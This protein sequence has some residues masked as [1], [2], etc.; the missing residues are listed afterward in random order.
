M[1][2]PPSRREQQQR[3]RIAQE[4][5]RLMI[6]GGLNDF[7]AAKR[8]AAERLGLGDQRQLLPNNREVEEARV[9]YQRL[10]RAAVQP[11]RLRQLRQS[12]VHTMK[13]LHRF[14]PRLVGPVLSGTADVNSA[15]NLHLFAATPEEVDLF[16]LEQLVPFER[17]ERRLRLDAEHYETY[18]M[19][20][21][22]AGEVRVE[23]TVFPTDGQRQAP[24]SPVDGRPMRRAGLAE[25]EALLVAG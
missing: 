24:L 6:D 5:A 22:L 23:L 14:A 17:D 4:A 3:A 16:L 20:R 12:A 25:V 21:L 1:A 7:G 19:V 18:P 9:E 10:F 15:V 8:K 2:R 13:F 11:E